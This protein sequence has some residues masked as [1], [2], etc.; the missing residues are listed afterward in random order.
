MSNE[1]K[2]EGLTFIE[3]VLA[4]NAGATVKRADESCDGSPM[5]VHE[6]SFITPGNIGRTP[7]SY[8]QLVMAVLSG[9]FDV[10]QALGMCLAPADMCAKDWMV[11]PPSEPLSE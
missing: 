5:V 6:G 2:T 3:A 4:A 7:P 1:G 8:E 11:V 9:R 10:D